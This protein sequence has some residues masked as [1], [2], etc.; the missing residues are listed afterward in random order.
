V[1]IGRRMEREEILE[2]KYYVKADGYL[3]LPRMR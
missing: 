1:F 2:M 3:R